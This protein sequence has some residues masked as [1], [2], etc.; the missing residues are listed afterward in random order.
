[1]ASAAKAAL[2]LQYSLGFNG[3]AVAELWQ[4]KIELGYD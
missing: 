1:M 4:E 3:C 2:I